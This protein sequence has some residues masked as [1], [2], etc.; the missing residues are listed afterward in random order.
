MERETA[1]TPTTM[2]ETMTEMRGKR[3][4]VNQAYVQEALP[5]IFLS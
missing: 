2:T 1:I 4:W 5:P 3:G